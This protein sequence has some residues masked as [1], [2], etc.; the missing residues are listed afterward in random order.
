MINGIGPWHWV[1][2]GG[3]GWRWIALIG[4]VTLVHA[5]IVLKWVADASPGEVRL[6][7]AIM[8]NDNSI[9]TI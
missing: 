6:N 8:R 7:H 5:R 1:A 3:I 4:M 9:V 2:L